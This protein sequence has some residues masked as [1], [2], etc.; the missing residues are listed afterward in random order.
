MPRPAKEQRGPLA[1]ARYLSLMSHSMS[2]A[3][4]TGVA[5]SQSIPADVPHSSNTSDSNTAFRPPFLDDRSVIDQQRSMRS[6]AIGEVGGERESEKSFTQKDRALGAPDP[7]DRLVPTTSYRLNTS[8]ATT[9]THTVLRNQ[10]SDVS[11]VTDSNMNRNVRGSYEG[12]YAVRGTAS[13]ASAAGQRRSNAVN[14]SAILSEQCSSMQAILFDE[15]EAG[16]AQATVQAVAGLSEALHVYAHRI[17]SMRDEKKRLVRMLTNIRSRDM[18]PRVTSTKSAPGGHDSQP[19]VAPTKSAPATSE[20]GWNSERSAAS[21]GGP[22]RKLQIDAGV[23][24][25]S[26]PLSLPKLSGSDQVHELPRLSTVDEGPAFG[27]SSSSSAEEQQV[28]KQDSLIS[29]WATDDAD[30]EGD[31]CQAELPRSSRPGLRASSPSNAPSA[32]IRRNFWSVRFG[33][34]ASEQEA[35]KRDLA[36]DSDDQE[37][38]DKPSTSASTKSVSC[39]PPA[40][41]GG[42]ASSAASVMAAAK[43]ASKALEAVDNHDRDSIHSTRT[44]GSIT[45]DSKAPRRSLNSEVSGIR[46]TG[47]QSTGVASNWEPDEPYEQEGSGT[48]D[49]LTRRRTN[50]LD[51]IRGE[52]AVNLGTIARA[53]SVHLRSKSGTFTTYQMMLKPAWDQDV[54]EFVQPTTVE[55]HTMRSALL[56]LM[57]NSEEIS[58]DLHSR[59]QPFVILP[60]A[61]RRFVWMLPGAL[62]I[63]Y[64]LVY[65]P[66]QVFEL[67]ASPFTLGVAWIALL[68]WSLDIPM[69]FFTGVYKS[70]EGRIEMRLGKIAK[71]YC[72]SWL[73]IDM[74]TVLPD[75]FGLM[76]EGSPEASGGASSAAMARLS[77]TFRIMRILRSVRLLRLAKLQFLVK[78]LKDRINSEYVFSFLQ[79]CALMLIL[80]CVSH[81]MA[82]GWYGLGRHSDGWVHNH[83]FIDRKVPNMYMTSLHWSLA[84]FQGNMEV[85]PI[86]FEER[87]FAVVVL[88]IGLVGISSL[89]SSI[90]NMMMELQNYK[91]ESTTQWWTLCRFLREQHVSMTTV[92]R[93]KKF[94]KHIMRGN[95][96]KKAD[97]HLIDKLPEHLQMEIDADVYSPTIEHHR[98][99][100]HYSE[101]SPRCMKL[102]CRGLQL[103]F[104]GQGDT[105]FGEGEAARSMYWVRRGKL[106]YTQAGGAGDEH[107]LSSGSWCSEPVLWVPWVHVGELYSYDPCE[108]LILSADD[109]E[110]ITLSQINAALLTIEYAQQFMRYVKDLNQYHLTDLMQKR[111]EPLQLLQPIMAKRRFKSSHLLEQKSKSNVFASM[112]FLDEDEGGWCSCLRDW[113]RRYRERMQNELENDSG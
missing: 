102:L 35:E 21:S 108:L 55:A 72:T 39:V 49:R 45:N 31:L 18:S 46:S 92:M 75:W 91:R 76:I 62:L 24:T 34:S 28:C 64:D 79:V 17:E 89:L 73:P 67:P 58:Y 65:I 42:R 41:H 40:L 19:K 11:R 8:T 93:V 86:L 1:D 101:E 77:K 29:D 15:H 54:N 61:K 4:G 50:I 23:Q 16:L 5:S 14:W 9:S 95:H 99:F 66:L 78:D 88:L 12:A 84:Q 52:S 110:E 106:L 47:G 38:H 57:D 80:I 2:A 22:F 37:R 27:G 74:V 56:G 43:R 70:K 103:E 107:M 30:A 44:D 69:S 83:H 26:L 68:Y 104:I 85:Y 20:E 71:A 33:Q 82:C 36:D 100:S 113:Y 10:S 87:V 48:G 25:D 53:N 111:V 97:V 98:F 60:Y 63:F 59:L 94:M 105:I 81:F 96:I 90:T 109:F 112:L 32:S 51:Q 6:F 7:P 3:G 13:M